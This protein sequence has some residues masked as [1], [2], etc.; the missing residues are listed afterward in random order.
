MSNN[1]RVGNNGPEDIR[2]FHGWAGRGADHGGN[3]GGNYQGGRGAHRGGRDPGMPRLDTVNGPNRGGNYQGSSGQRGA[4][5]GAVA[6]RSGR[7]DNGN[8]G[9]GRGY[10]GYYRGSGD[11]P[12]SRNRGG[13]RGLGDSGTFHGHKK[14][15]IV[16]K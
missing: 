6:F 15:V 8:F 13:G 14:E 3:R 2:G 4:R 1:H 11:R 12:A 9:G 7:G 5:G 16:Y 10:D